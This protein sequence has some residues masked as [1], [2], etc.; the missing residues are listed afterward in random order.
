MRLTA[1]SKERGVAFFHS[2]DYFAKMRRNY[3]TQSIFQSAFLAKPRA[4][5]NSRVVRQT[6]PAV[7]FER[8]RRYEKR[9]GGSRGG[10]PA[11]GI[12]IGDVILVFR[13][14]EVVVQPIRSVE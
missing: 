9:R 14:A 11:L 2:E 12:F 7:T 5:I 1:H 8:Q 3:L 4:T 13:Y 10:C 6:G